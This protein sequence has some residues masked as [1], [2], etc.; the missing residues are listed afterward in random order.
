M[1]VDDSTR[2]VQGGTQGRYLEAYL[3]TGPIYDP[4]WTN[5]AQNAL[6]EAIMALNGPIYSLNDPILASWPYIQGP[7]LMARCQGPRVLESG[8]RVLGTRC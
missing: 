7:S 5:M 8:A 3:P 4:I 6:Y 1:Y 2:V